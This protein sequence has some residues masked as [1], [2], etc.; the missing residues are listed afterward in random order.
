MDLDQ[1]IEKDFLTCRNKFPDVF[2]KDLASQL[3]TAL[4]QYYTS[5]DKL[6]NVHTYLKELAIPQ[7]VLFDILANRF[8]LVLGAQK[9]V[10]QKITEKSKGANQITIV[11]LGVGRGIQILRIIEALASQGNTNI[12]I[13]GIDI[14]KDALEFTQLKLN[15]FAKTTNI[16]IQFHP[17]LASIEHVTAQQIHQLI[18]PHNELTFVNASLAIHHLQE[19]HARE[20]LFKTV[21]QLQPDLFSIIEP[22]ADTFTSN[23][24][25]RMLN[26]YIHFTCLYA[27]INTLELSEEEK[28]GLK[29]FF[30]NDFSDTIINS[31]EARYE[32]YEPGLNWMQ[33]GIEF[34]FKTINANCNEL[35]IANIDIVKNRDAKT[36]QEFISFRYR[37]WDVLSVLLFETDANQ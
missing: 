22:Y 16:Q 18:P 19:I 4:S 28:R 1:Q 25:Q 10:Q 35:T 37:N 26:S 32:K 3:K 2:D 8:P 11:D 36:L 15:E 24:E 9:I 23:R 13:I 27:Y 17:I 30:Y 31:E 7:I 12:N 14:I 5:S 34:G 33:R 20:K 6:Q 29:A 21:S